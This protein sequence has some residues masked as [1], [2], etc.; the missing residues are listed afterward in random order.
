LAG[1]IDG[2]SRYLVVAST[3]QFNGQRMARDNG[4]DIG[5]VDVA[6]LDIV[7][8]TFFPVEAK[9]LTL[10]K[11]PGEV[12]NELEALFST[13]NKDSAVNHHLERIQWLT[14]H[15]SDVLQEFGV[16]TADVAAWTIEPILVLDGNLL[17]R[18]LADSPFPVMT[19]T[20]FLKFL[21][22]RG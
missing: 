12:K 9:S 14:S 21:V 18:Y 6:M 2:Q 7:S 5:D 16:C 15:L 17:S 22:E 4:E 20:E 19:E 3:K 13:K 8:K 10:A 1:K 11:T